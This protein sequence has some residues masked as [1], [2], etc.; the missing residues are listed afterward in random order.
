MNPDSPFLQGLCLDGSVCAVWLTRTRIAENDVELGFSS[1][2]TYVG[3][4]SD[5]NA[6]ILT[7]ES[8][9]NP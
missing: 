1:Q 7:F 3:Y 2:G 5:G 4:S 6:P 9:F 8:S